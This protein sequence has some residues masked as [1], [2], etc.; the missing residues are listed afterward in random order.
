MADRGRDRDSGRDKKA[1]LPAPVAPRDG[2]PSVD[3]RGR[4]E[5][6]PESFRTRESVDNPGLYSRGCDTEAQGYQRISSSR[7]TSEGNSVNENRRADARRYHN[8]GERCF[9]TSVMELE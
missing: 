6:Y 8:H 9:I 4:F 2:D 7:D 5:G 1:H 3:G